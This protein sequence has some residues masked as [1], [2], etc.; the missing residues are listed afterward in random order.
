MIKK[1]WNWAFSF[2]LK[3]TWITYSFE[4][5]TILGFGR[6][7]W[8]NSVSLH[9]MATGL[10]ST[11]FRLCIFWES[12]VSLPKNFKFYELPVSQ[13][14]KLITLWNAVF[15]TS[16]KKGTPKLKMYRNTIRHHLI[17]IFPC[18]F[19]FRENTGSIQ[20]FFVQLP[21]KYFCHFSNAFFIFDCEHSSCG[22]MY[23]FIFFVIVE[24]VI[25]TLLAPKSWSEQSRT[26]FSLVSLYFF[27]RFRSLSN[28]GTCH[29]CIFLRSSGVLLN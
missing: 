3:S 6:L 15:W 17:L 11:G 21:S 9:K 25:L 23:Y 2:I 26:N 29:F 22:P 20:R 10:V 14:C 27:I 4:G 28:I 16:L 7:E 24:F 18:I 12:V 8:I 1:L 5:H 19:L 13:S